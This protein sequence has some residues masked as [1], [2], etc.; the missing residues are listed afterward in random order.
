LVKL[1]TKELANWAIKLRA[2][3]LPDEVLAKAEDCIIDAI[4]SAIPG[5]QF[6]GAKRVH[7]VAGNTY[8]KGDAGVWFSSEHLHPTGAAFANAASASVLDIDDG[9]RRAN[10]HPGAAVIPSV[11]A[12]SHSDTKGIDILANI[13]ACY[14]ICVRIGMSENHRS[15]HTGNYT[16]FGAAVAVA[17]AGGLSAEQLM[18]AL[19]ITV[20]HGPRVADLTLSMDMGANVKESIPWSVV[21][22]MMGANLAQQGFTGCCDALNIEERFMPAIALE[23]L[24]DCYFPISPGGAQAS[25]AIL[26]IYFKRYACCR[27]C[28]SAVEGLLIIMRK[29]KLSASDIQ[30]IR[31]ETFKQSANLNNLADPP[32]LESAQY[33]VPYCMAIAAILGEDALTPMS[34]DSLHNSTVVNLAVRITVVHDE[35]LDPMFP[36]QNPS[37]VIVTAADGVFEDFVVAPWGEPDLPPSRADL[38][39][40]FQALAKDRIPQDQA[41]NIMTAVQGLRAG[42]VAPLLEALTPPVNF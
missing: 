24:E 3:D 26:R 29:Q 7:C 41:N 13:V 4:A 14:E 23:G 37:R 38:V 11:L 33:S 34:S 32:S 6:E 31:V 27:W 10:G 25:Y 21:A 12:A 40:K 35:K 9:H 42:K 30:H 15:Y 18:H 8:G 1:V 36:A 2:E 17:R 5:R 19:A 22:G 39:G 20:Y 16:G 28:H